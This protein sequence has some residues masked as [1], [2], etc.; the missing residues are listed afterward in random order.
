MKYHLFF[1]VLSL[2]KTQ[3]STQDLSDILI[4]SVEVKIGHLL[5]LFKEDLSFS[6]TVLERIRIILY[7]ASQVVSEDAR[8]TAALS[9]ALTYHLSEFYP[10]QPVSFFNATEPLAIRYTAHLGSVMALAFENPVVPTSN[11]SHLRALLAEE[12]NEKHPLLSIVTTEHPC[13]GIPV[14][15]YKKA[16]EILSAD[17]S[18]VVGRV[19]ELFAIDL[20]PTIPSIQKSVDDVFPF[21]AMLSEAAAK[22]VQAE[23]LELK[24]LRKFFQPITWIRVDYDRAPNHDR[25]FT[26]GMLRLE[27]KVLE[28]YVTLLDAINLNGDRAQILQDLQTLHRHVD[29]SIQLNLALAS[30]EIRPYLDASGKL[31]KQMPKDIQDK[32]KQLFSNDF[33]QLSEPGGTPKILLFALGN[34]L[35][36]HNDLSAIIAR[37]DTIKT[38]ETSGVILA[39][40]SEMTVLGLH[41]MAAQGRVDTHVVRA[42][43]ATL[44]PSAPRD[45][46]GLRGFLLKK[47]SLEGRLDPEKPET[48]FTRPLMDYLR[49]LAMLNGSNPDRIDSLVLAN[50]ELASDV[51]SAQVLLKIASDSLPEEVGAS[52]GVS[53]FP[54][55]ESASALEGAKEVLHFLESV[56]KITRFMKAFSDIPRGSGLGNGVYALLGATKATW[57]S[58]EMS[59]MRAHQGTGSGPMRFGGH[60]F[61]KLLSLL[62]AQELRSLMLTVQPGTLHHF[63]WNVP[64]AEKF[65]D[66]MIG[67]IQNGIENPVTLNEDQIKFLKEFNAP[68]GEAYQSFCGTAEGAKSILSELGML[69]H[70]WLRENPMVAAAMKF[71]WS[72][73]VK[74]FGKIAE[75]PV[76]TE[77][78][79]TVA[80]FT[81]LTGGPIGS[82]VDF[83]ASMTAY[84]SSGKTLEDLKIMVK[85]NSVFEF[86]IYK[87][88]EHFNLISLET[89]HQSMVGHDKLF[90]AISSQCQEGL[91]W[92]SEI[93]GSPDLQGS[94]AAYAKV[95]SD[96]VK[97]EQHQLTLSRRMMGSALVGWDSQNVGEKT[98]PADNVSAQMAAIVSAMAM[99]WRGH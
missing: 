61:E 39:L 16:A 83:H 72:S 33:S 82:V 2:S 44:F 88:I 46:V 62:G 53:F 38:D 42:A 1:K 78:A 60:L 75:F 89:L 22:L 45:E 26:D 81:M 19:K 79:I 70:A 7:A 68:G 14:D 35:K 99:G 65:L 90:S 15:V 29:Q 17:A 21:L 20:V 98:F 27:K 95:D 94:Y 73:R 48:E 55:F 52:S 93:V 58:K 59:A 47:L 50:C 5:T 80:N 43:F 56:E 71:P 69:Y 87:M 49:N 96:L 24:D 6:D 36:E 28:R 97:F 12:V 74:E 76:Q 3:R 67:L 84:L 18:Q 64:A 4:K 40:Q 54:L 51:L 66:T 25:I 11:G 63:A 77:R 8:Q 32:F 91:S 31:D 92:L 34:S 10:P 41:G 23:H 30:L 37:L 13:R 86:E 57:G 9:T 85:E